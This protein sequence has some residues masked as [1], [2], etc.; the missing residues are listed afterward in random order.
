M[1]R[2]A[3]FF[4]MSCLALAGSAV[5]APPRKPAKP[6]TIFV[7]PPAP[8]EKPEVL[9][10]RGKQAMEAKN[11]AGAARDIELA[12]AAGIAE[13]CYYQGE[14]LRTGAA[15]KRD[16]DAALSA[17][18][19]ACEAGDARSCNSFA[20]NQLP[21]ARDDAARA[22]NTAFLA[23]ACAMDHGQACSNLAYRIEKG[24][25]IAQDKVEAL[26]LYRKA[27]DLKYAGGCRNAAISLEAGNGAE[28]DLAGALALYQKGCELDELDSCFWA[29]V[30]IEEGK[31]TTPD[32]ITARGLYGKN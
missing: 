10:E 25:G 18:R 14:L 21:F 19:K 30:A 12:C 29:A 7:P 16:I 27:C 5:A 28:K 26:R 6:V 9:A 3:A 22:Q 15:G 2:L 13:S 17:Y 24:T 11:Y 1:L 8:V 23:R 20:V 32:K 31:G 4:V